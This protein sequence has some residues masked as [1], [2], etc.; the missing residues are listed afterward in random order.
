MQL[1]IAITI[2][3][4][5][6]KLAL[7]VI[8]KAQQ[9]GPTELDLFIIFTESLC[10]CVLEKGWKDNRTIYIWYDQAYRPYFAQHDSETG[11][12]LDELVCPKSHELKDDNTM[13]FLIPLG[14][15]CV[16]QP[17]YVEIN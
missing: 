1:I 17:Y 12:L 8:L 10:R 2:A 15:S 7:F 3:M 5:G 11:F 4:D 13:R 16:L 6:S 14:Y 9:D